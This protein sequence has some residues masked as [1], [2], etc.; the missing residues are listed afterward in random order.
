MSP[1]NTAGSEFGA[2]QWYEMWLVVWHGVAIASILTAPIWGC[3]RCLSA[4]MANPVF[5]FHKRKWKRGNGNERWKLVTLIISPCSIFFS[6]PGTLSS[7][8]TIV[9]PYLVFISVTPPMWSFWGEQNTNWGK[10]LYPFDT[11]TENLD[12][13]MSTHTSWWW[14]Q[15]RYFKATFWDD[16]SL[17]QGENSPTSII[18]ASFD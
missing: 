9:P 16:T 18:A 4:F 12:F 17:E 8:E 1:V 10:A 11:Q 14:V 3:Q 2:V 7:P 13:L 5:A 15:R 6:T